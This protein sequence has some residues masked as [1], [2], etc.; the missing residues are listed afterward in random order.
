MDIFNTIGSLSRR[1]RGGM[2]Q[3]PVRDWLVLITFST[4]ALIGIIVWNA[5]AFDTVASGGVIGPS[6][7]GTAPVFDSSSLEDIH[8]IFENRAAEE[9]KYVTGVYRYADPSQ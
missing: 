4:I 9:S 3:D 6:V 7:K 5:W 8:I 1:L 2:H